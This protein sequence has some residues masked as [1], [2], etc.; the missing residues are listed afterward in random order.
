MRETPRSQG[1]AGDARSALPRLRPGRALAHN[2]GTPRA[3]GILTDRMSARPIPPGARGTPVSAAASEPPPLFRGGRPLFPGSAG[4]SGS[5]SRRFSPPAARCWRAALRRAHLAG[6]GPRPAAH[7]R[8]TAGAR[9]R[10]CRGLPVRAAE[11]FADLGNTA[12][13]LPVLLVVMVWAGW[14]AAAWLREREGS[15]AAPSAGGPVR[16]AGGCRRSPPASRWPR[17]PRWSSRSSCGWPGR[18]RRRWPAVRTTASIR[19]ATG[20][21]RRWRTAWPRCC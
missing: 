12:V 2:T 4:P 3:P 21:R 13:A 9:R 8:R 11:F 15:R 10:R 5:G 6:G 16:C 18:V 14:R 20:P 7:P 19:R 1:T 17:C